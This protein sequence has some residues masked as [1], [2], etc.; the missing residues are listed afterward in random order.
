M[1]GERTAAERK[2]QHKNCFVYFFPFLIKYLFTLEFY[3]LM[4]GPTIKT[5]NLYSFSPLIEQVFE[6]VIAMLRLQPEPHFWNY[7]S[8]FCIYIHVCLI[9]NYK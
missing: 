8:L 7:T 9:E 1:Q 2:K 6:T 4:D 5:D 3:E